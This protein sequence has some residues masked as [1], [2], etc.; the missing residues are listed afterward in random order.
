MRQTLAAL[1]AGG[2]AGQGSDLGAAC[3]LCAD[4]QPGGHLADANQFELAG[5]S[6]GAQFAHRFAMLYPQMVSRLTVSFGGLVHLS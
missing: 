1:P 6:G 3:L 5:Y 2:A 4:L